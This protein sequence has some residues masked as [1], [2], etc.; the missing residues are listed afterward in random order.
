[1]PVSIYE[2]VVNMGK[3]YGIRKH[4]KG[5]KYDDDCLVLDSNYHVLKYKYF[6]SARFMCQ[7]LTKA[8]S[9]RCTFTIV[10]LD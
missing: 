9:G 3:L 2:K 7:E 4:T 6:E 10:R 1:M 8:H 5:Q